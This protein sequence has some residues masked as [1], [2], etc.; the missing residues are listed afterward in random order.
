MRQKIRT[1]HRRLEPLG[2]EGTSESPARWLLAYETGAGIPHGLGGILAA[3]L[4]GYLLV[5][6]RGWIKALLRSRRT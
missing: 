6:I 3:L 4:A 2:P 1:P 5:E